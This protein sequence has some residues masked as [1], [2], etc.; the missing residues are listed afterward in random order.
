MHLHGGLSVSGVFCTRERLPLPFSCVCRASWAVL[1]AVLLGLPSGRPLLSQDRLL[2]VFHFNRLSTADGLPSN[3]VRSNI[4]TDRQGFVW[5]GTVNGLARYDGYTCR[6]YRNNP[7]D[8]SSISSNGI[9]SLLIDSRGLLWVGTFDTGFSI[10]DAANDRF[11][12][13]LPRGKDSTLLGLKAILMMYEDRA[14]NIWFSSYENKIILADMSGLSHETNVDSVAAR[15]RFQVLRLEGSK[16]AVYIGEWDLHSL[17]FG[18]ARGLR[19]YNRDT[20]QISGLSLPASSSTNLDTARITAFWWESTDR[21]WIATRSNGL[22]LWDRAGK[23]LVEYRRQPARRR[24]PRDERITDILI[25]NGGRMWITTPTTLDLFDPMSGEYKEY[26]LT[27]SAPPRNPY[28]LSVDRM[29]RL[30]VS[31]MDDGL[32]FLTPQ[33]MRFPHF[34]LKGTDG[35]PKS[36]ETI[37]EAGDGTY[38]IASEGKVVRVRIA[39]LG[40]FQ[41]VDL[42]KGMRP[43]YWRA[44]VMDSYRDSEGT[45]WYGTW[46]LGLYRFEPGTGSVTNY[47]F[48]TQLP[49]L[50]NKN[51]V[52]F[53]I[54]GGAGDS[55]WIGAYRDGLLEFDTRTRKFSRRTTVGSTTPVNVYQVM[56]DKGGRLWISD[57]SQGVLVLDPATN[58]AEHFTHDPDRP[59]TLSDDRGRHVYQGPDGDIWIGT[60]GLH[61]WHP[62]SRSFTRFTNGA[63]RN[64]NFVMPMGTDLQDRLW[65]Y[66]YPGAVGILNRSTGRFSNFG[67]SDG[68]CANIYEMGRLQDGTVLLLGW[69][70][71]NIIN[72]ESLRT[73]HQIPPLVFG[74]ILINDT[75]SVSGHNPPDAG[76]AL[77]HDQNSLELEFSAIDPGAGHMIEYHYRLEGLEDSWVRPAGR[78]FVR[79]PGLAPGAY[80]FRVRAVSQM[81][82]WPDQE[83]ALS[84]S[85]APPFWRTWW[86]YAMYASLA[87]GLLLLGYR[88]RLNRLRLAQ[89]VEM[90]HFQSERLAEVDRLKS[91]FFANVSHEFRTPLTLILGLNEQLA[92]L[93]NDPVGF[94]GKQQLVASNAKQLLRL[95]NELL[96]LSRLESGNMRLQVSNGDIVQFL[97]RVVLSF[98]SWAERKKIRLEFKSKTD[99]IHGLF[100]REKLETIVNNLI[101]NALKFTPEGGEVMVVVQEAA[102]DRPLQLTVSDSGPGIPADHLPHIFERFYRTDEAHAT[103]GAG[104]GLALAKELTELH[105]GTIRVAS[106][107]GKGSLFTVEI[108]VNSAA[109]RVEEFVEG[110]PG[111]D[112]FEVPP[113]GTLSKK[114]GPIQGAA[115][116]S[117]KPIVLVV[118]DNAD[119]RQ[120][121]RE[122]FEKEYAV[123]EA[124]DGKTGFD[125]A[126]EIVPDMVISD[127]MMPEMD[128]MRLCRAL[129]QDIRTSHVPVILLTA[130]AGIDSKLEGLETGADDYVEK[131]FDAKELL[132]RVRNLIEQRRELRKRFSAGAVLRPGEV[133]V[134]SLDNALLKRAMAYVE[135]RIGDE[136][137]GVDDL[138]R[139]MS[140]SRATLNRKL[141]ALTNLSPA[142]FIRYLRLQRARELLEKNA[143]TVA[144]IAYQV[145]FGSPS[146]FSAAFHERFG[147]PPSEIQPKAE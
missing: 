74:R 29:G 9:M 53:S 45:L 126:V 33:S 85:I 46:G 118:E 94:K 51:D 105:R 75:L 134:T 22:Y 102:G 34:A 115:P 101:S 72:P 95:V 7:D 139:E 28:L 91:R 55:L 125:R 90:E 57:E 87:I 5:I 119:L 86:A 124:P 30:W 143:G 83:L 68:L 21:L 32:Y 123:Q 47:R 19:I 122:H 135:Q 8:P 71:M 84:I 40:V 67:A 56:K 17:L 113:A 36:M 13:F 77:D 138:S 133:A 70:G 35:S 127:V 48:S 11:V 4:V 144:E 76:L 98:A 64:T 10:Y 41:T 104:I 1:L 66:Y 110:P 82:Q 80:V 107:P 59:T 15:A 61:L 69:S 31:T 108:P 52:C 63:F 128:G 44:G 112:Q 132:A 60:K 12:N 20:R 129:K 18:T 147:I 16:E 99:S 62:E 23:S 109:Y 50:T 27:R 103:E 89:Q 24:D 39:D 37:D 121:I 131:P 25:D 106:S 97:R 141:Q 146:H 43:T 142:E 137:L 65:V 88:L 42:F 120:H 79:Y 81:S 58:S 145:G 49:D 93:L 130:R 3:E 140:V 100:D 38:W 116:T 111:R 117:G 136:T 92:Q 2:P 54:T 78:R 14:G 96:D 6:V 73:A 114:S 26:L